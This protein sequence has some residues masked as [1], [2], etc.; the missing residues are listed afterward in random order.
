M[1]T[2][3]SFYTRCTRTDKD[4]LT[5]RETILE[6]EAMFMRPNLAKIELTNKANKQDFERIFFKEKHIFNYLPRE[7][8]V[9]VHEIPPSKPNEENVI[10]SFLRGMK[11]ADAKKRF[12]MSLQKENE[13]YAYILIS[14]KAAADQQDFVQAQLA[15]WIKNPPNQKPNIEF[16]PSRFWYREPNKKEVTY[17]FTDIVPNAELDKAKFS[18]TKPQDW[19]VK[20]ANAPQPKGPQPAPIIRNQIKP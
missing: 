4:A 5:K 10:L 3:E 7:K 2:L 14:P 15:V 1:L 13:Y 8:V 12:A 11:P 18:P 16:M 19:E 9:M 20:Y 6:G 17:L